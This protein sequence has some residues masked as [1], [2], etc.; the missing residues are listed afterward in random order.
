[1]IGIVDIDSYGSCPGSANPGAAAI[2]ITDVNR[3][4]GGR[5][6]RRRAG[7]SIGRCWRVRRCLGWSGC[8]GC[9]G[10]IGRRRGRGW[11]AG[12]GV[13]R[14]RCGG[15]C[16]SYRA[17][18]RAGRRCRISR[19]WRTTNIQSIINQLERGAGTRGRD[20]LNPTTRAAQFQVGIM[21]SEQAA[22]RQHGLCRC[23]GVAAGYCRF[24]K[25]ARPVHLLP[26]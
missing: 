18:R 15:P 20:P 14:S 8:V 4:G 22:A 24:P 6:I 7:R 19:S 1:M 23:N 16:R 26:E 11:R 9:C 3:A 13:S 12:R 5:C 21:S 17:G 10:G 2:Q 25:S